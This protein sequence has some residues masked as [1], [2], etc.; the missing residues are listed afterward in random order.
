MGDQDSI[1]GE[2]CISLVESQ[3]ITKSILKLI[4]QQSSAIIVNKHMN[5]I[6]P[7]LGY[8]WFREQVIVLMEEYN[9]RSDN[10]EE[11]VIEDPEPIAVNIEHWRRCQGQVTQGVSKENSHSPVIQRKDTKIM[12]KLMTIRT[13]RPSECFDSQLIKMG[14]SED[15][16]EFDPNIESI[17]QAKLRQITIQQQK[18]QNDK[19]KVLEVQEQVKQLKRLNVDSKSKY[20]FDYEGKVV[21]QKP[22]DFERYPKS[23]QNI[24]EKRSLVEVRDLIPNH[25]VQSELI[26]L[27]SKNSQNIGQNN[28]FAIKTSVSQIELMIMKEGVTFYD[29]KQEKKKNRTF[30]L[31]DI[32][33]P[34]QLQQTLQRQ[35]VQ[36]SKIEYE[37]IT[38]TSQNNN[39]YHNKKM[40]LSNS[41]QQQ[42]HQF[43]TR[44]QQQNDDLQNINDSLVSQRAPKN[45]TTMNHS[46]SS[47]I[48]QKL[49]GSISILS[50]QQFEELLIP[51]T[52]G[53]RDQRDHPLFL[54][55]K[56]T[57]VEVKPAKTI[58]TF[59]LP[60]IPPNI[61]SN[62][63]SKLPRSFQSQGTFPKLIPKFPRQRI[64]KQAIQLKIET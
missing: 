44:F 32:K 19:I 3:W 38:S 62:T 40:S 46:I 34:L 53:N 16:Q 58:P 31:M 23:F 20:T 43:T 57:E 6:L 30:P 17:R 21:V 55:R 25:K 33:D 5:S 59:E 41:Q 24:S 47:S 22:P 1:Y 45:L 10:V 48:I 42:S 61:L 49:N 8:N 14:D 54:K 35:N 52:E 39:N 13:S 60:Q 29:G 4:V 27:T 11:N 18:E 64:S 51:Q 56:K 15:E 36:M 50:E 12:S 7:Q 28:Q 63:L 9:L 37:Q 26:Q 2:L